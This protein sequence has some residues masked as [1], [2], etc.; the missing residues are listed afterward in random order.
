MKKSVL[1]ENSESLSWIKLMLPYE[2]K[3][4]VYKLTVA[5]L[6]SLYILYKNK[7][8]DLSEYITK[9]VEKKVEGR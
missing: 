9:K 4:L 2:K 8:E 7:L 6:D 1:E 5:E 3:D